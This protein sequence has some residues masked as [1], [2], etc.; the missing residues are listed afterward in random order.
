MHI[1][2]LHYQKSP[3]SYQNYPL[4]HRD[5]PQPQI[6]ISV[7]LFTMTRFHHLISGVA[8]SRNRT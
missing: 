1:R 2:Y 3:F 6:C 8:V 7:S 4:C 5:L